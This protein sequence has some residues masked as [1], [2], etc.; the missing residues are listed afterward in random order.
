MMRKCLGL[1]AMAAV[2]VMLGAGVASAKALKQNV[3]VT[4]EGTAKVILNYSQGEAGLIA[5]V[6]ASGLA[7]DTTYTVKVGVLVDVIDPLTGL[8]SGQTLNVYG[9]GTFTTKA[10]KAK[11]N[12]KGN[13]EPKKPK[14]CKGHVNIHI[15]WDDPENPPVLLEL[16]VTV[17]GAVAP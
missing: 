3:A 10:D 4:P 14:N 2:V 13:G 5:N 1:L 9:E 16:T 15:P 7:P 8:V 12:L 17:T 11:N 6:N